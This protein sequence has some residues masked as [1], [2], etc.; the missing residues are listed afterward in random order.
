M[1]QILKKS[2]SCIPLWFVTQNHFG[3]IKKCLTIKSSKRKTLFCF[4]VHDCFKKLLF[5]QS[6][7]ISIFLLNWLDFLIFFIVWIETPHQY[8]LREEAERSQGILKEKFVAIAEAALLF[9]HKI[10]MA[11]G[12]G[13]INELIFSYLFAMTLKTSNNLVF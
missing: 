2:K 11:K 8:S 4:Y 3:R 13:P 9:F 6:C 5:S 10:V 1:S 12:W 7:K